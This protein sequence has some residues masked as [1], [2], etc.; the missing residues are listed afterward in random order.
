VDLNASGSQ[1]F[2]TGGSPRISCSNPKV[3][4]LLAAERQVLQF[5]EAQRIIRPLPSEPIC[6]WNMKARK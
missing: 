1:Y 2:A 5:R 6:A 4:E 3:D